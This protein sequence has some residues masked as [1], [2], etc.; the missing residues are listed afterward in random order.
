MDRHEHVLVVLSA[1]PRWSVPSNQSL[2]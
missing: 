1:A 2:C